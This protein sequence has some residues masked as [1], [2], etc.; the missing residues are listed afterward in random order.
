MCVYIC[1]CIYMYI[2]VCIYINNTKQNVPDD[3]ID[4]DPRHHRTHRV[5]ASADRNP[6]TGCTICATCPIFFLKC[7]C[8]LKKNMCVHLKTNNKVYNLCN[9]SYFFF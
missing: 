5:C 4:E 9:L 1:V 3:R 7:V 2:C 8:I 6:T